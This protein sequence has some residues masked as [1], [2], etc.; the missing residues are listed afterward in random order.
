MADDF[1][2]TFTENLRLR[3]IDL[4]DEAAVAQV[5]AFYR[6]PA[7]WSHLPEACPRDDAEVRDYLAGH[8]R[9]WRERGLGW[10]FISVLGSGART[11]GKTTA[12]TDARTGLRMDSRTDAD[13]DTVVG[14]G[15]CALTRPGI[16]AWN[17]GYRLDPAVWGR[18]YATEA[19]RAGLVAARSVRPELPI[20]ARALERNPASCRVLD[21]LGLTV[22][23]SGEA[24]DD[25]LV[26][27][28]LRRIYSDR[29]LDLPLL[30]QLVSL[31]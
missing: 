7:T 18:G 30:D 2:D 26:R 10:W 6:D 31:G 13:A 17:L 14:I 5:C 24:S 28:L 11:D 22:V 9:S 4:G 19:S 8:A 15:G 12:R 29:D 1:A 21:K 25:P 20:T 16:P 23:W 3:P 27:G